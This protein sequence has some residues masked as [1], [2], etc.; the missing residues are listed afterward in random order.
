VRWA[1]RL[2]LQLVAPQAYPALPP[3][4]LRVCSAHIDSP[5]RFKLWPVRGSRVADVTVTAVITV[6]VCIVFSPLLDARRGPGH[7]LLPDYQYASL[8]S[9]ATLPPLQSQHFKAELLRHLFVPESDVRGFFSREAPAMLKHS[10]GPVTF[11]F[12]AKSG[13]YALTPAPASAVAAGGTAPPRYS[14]IVRDAP[15]LGHNTLDLTYLW[16]LLHYDLLPIDAILFTHTDAKRTPQPGDGL[17]LIHS[18]YLLPLVEFIAAHASRHGVQPRV[19]CVD[20]LSVPAGIPLGTAVWREVDHIP[21]FGGLDGSGLRDTMYAALGIEY[22]AQPLRTMLYVKRGHSRR[23]VNSPQVES[24]LSTWASAHGFAFS[25]VDLGNRSHGSVAFADQ[26]RLFAGT[27]ILVA[28]H[29]AG[30]FNAVFMRRGAVV[31]EVVPPSFRWNLFRSLSF[32][33]GV[34]HLQHYA[35]TAGEGCAALSCSAP[36]DVAALEHSVVEA[37]DRWLS[38]ARHMHLETD[39]AKHSEKVWPGSAG[40]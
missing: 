14:Y 34:Q 35:A 30:L 17:A 33:V 4:L 23:I 8:T 16:A 36:V 10:S 6:L 20:E 28:M 24:Y 25:A 40:C 3:F 37:H 5:R 39:L 18:G 21:W 1:F 15:S 19:Y 31:V 13:G 29:G 22:Q 26:V 38:V 12:L 9:N 27:G 2:P 7:F 11:M 32:A